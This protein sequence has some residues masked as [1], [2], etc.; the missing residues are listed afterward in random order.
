MESILSF[1]GVASADGQANPLLVARPILWANP[2]VLN[3]WRP[4][5]LIKLS[6]EGAIYPLV[7]TAIGWNLVFVILEYFDILFN[8]AVSAAAPALMAHLITLALAKLSTH[9]ASHTIHRPWL[10]GYSDTPS[11]LLPSFVDSPTGSR[12]AGIPTL[13]RAFLASRRRSRRG[14]IRMVKYVGV[15]V[16]LYSGNFVSLLLLQ[17]SSDCSAW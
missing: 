12:I 16:P 15:G 14:A 6:V 1:Y 11:G 9:V 3:N 10:Y 17:F 4:I 5:S 8:W 13:F 2:L 7:S